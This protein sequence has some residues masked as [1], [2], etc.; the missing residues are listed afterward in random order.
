MYSKLI[1]IFL[2]SWVFRVIRLNKIAS[3]SLKA[4]TISMR[5]IDIYRIII[6][7]KFIISL[8]IKC[9]EYK[10]KAA[11]SLSLIMKH[12][13]EYCV[14]S[15][16]YHGY[17]TAASGQLLPLMVW[18]CLILKECLHGFWGGREK[19]KG[20]VRRHTVLWNSSVCNV[21]HILFSSRFWDCFIQVAVSPSLED[22][23]VCF[24]GL[25]EMTKR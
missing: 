5:K 6:S 2:S 13:G 17:S 22:S 19:K 24:W 23:T 14:T 4:E 8:H 3:T 21:T 15:S 7:D 25:R 11:T 9:I 12:T 18:L 20:N 16:Q 10:I 1:L